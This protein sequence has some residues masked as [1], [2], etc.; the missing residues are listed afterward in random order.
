MIF[1]QFPDAEPFRHPLPPP[2]DEPLTLIN[3]HDGRSFLRGG[4]CTK[5]CG[6]CCTD[7]ILEVVEP[8]NIADWANWLELHNIDLVRKDGHL[9][10]RLR[11]ACS[12]LDT[13]DGT[14]KLFG[15]P[16]RPLMCSQ[17]PQAPEAMEGLN[18][19]T[20]RFAMVPK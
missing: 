1:D 15:K 5:G 19:C 20:Y 14:C 6:A 4:G 9:F 18:C 17:F 3:L 8:P 10:A 16:E 13:R 11:E 2:Q 7:V 12:Q